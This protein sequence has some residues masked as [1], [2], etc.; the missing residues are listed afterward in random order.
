MKLRIKLTVED[1]Y[2]YLGTSPS[3]SLTKRVLQ[4]MPDEFRDGYNMKFKVVKQG[5]SYHNWYRIAITVDTTEEKIHKV[6]DWNSKCMHKF[7]NFSYKPVQ[8][9]NLS[10]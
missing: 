3:M 8:Q 7:L 9:K 10:H 6:L 2:D 5:W 4:S 1:F